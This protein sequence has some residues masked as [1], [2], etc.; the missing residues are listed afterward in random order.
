MGDDLSEGQG[1]GGDAG[2]GA[3]GGGAAG[4]GT[5]GGTSFLT[6]FGTLQRG[7]RELLERH[8]PTVLERGEGMGEEQRALLLEQRESAS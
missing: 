6:E 5:A 3:A 1:G 7:V 8:L 2:G 4:G